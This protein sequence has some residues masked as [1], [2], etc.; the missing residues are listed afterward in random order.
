MAIVQALKN[1]RKYLHGAVI[2]NR[3]VH[4]ELTFLKTCKFVNA[5]LTRW[6][7]PIQDYKIKIEH[8]PRKDNI[9]VDVLSRINNSQSYKKNRGETQ[10]VINVLNYQWTQEIE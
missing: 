6:I 1:F 7:L 4:L 2:I 3:T 9:M 5:R 8:L 10:I